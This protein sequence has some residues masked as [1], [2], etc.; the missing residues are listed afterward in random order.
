MRS[1]F[2]LPHG[3]AK[4]NLIDVDDLAEVISELVT[5]EKFETDIYELTGHSYTKNEIASIFS[6]G[7]GREIT[8]V[9]VDEETAETSMIRI[10]HA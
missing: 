9:N 5:Q 2:Y 6:N 1:T 7:L 8:Y 3:D 4:V 10:G